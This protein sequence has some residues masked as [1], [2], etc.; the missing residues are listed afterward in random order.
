MLALVVSIIVK[1]NIKQKNVIDCI[2]LDFLF[3]W[4]TFNS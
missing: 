3:F 2:K 1:C 4:L